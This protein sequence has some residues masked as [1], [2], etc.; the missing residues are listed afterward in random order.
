M[1]QIA[2]LEH[3]WGIPRTRTGIT[4]IKIM[5]PPR[6]H[7][8]RTF[9]SPASRQARRR[10]QPPLLASIQ[11][12]VHDENLIHLTA[13][14]AAPEV[15]DLPMEEEPEH[16]NSHYTLLALHQAEKTPARAFL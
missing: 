16:E 7:L 14:A 6:R 3:H 10:L 15:L 12:A 1:Q 9:L 8:R 11:P 2:N 13:E 5:G 4:K